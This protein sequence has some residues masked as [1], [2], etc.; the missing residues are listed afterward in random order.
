MF[1][2]K[3][4]NDNLNRIETLIGENCSIVGNL[5]GTGLLKI[6]GVIE[7]DIDWD[8]DII[9]GIN[10]EVNGAIHC[11]NA[12][13]SGTVNGNVS[14]N[15][16]LTIEKQGKIKGDIFIKKLIINESGFLDGKCTMVTLNETHILLPEN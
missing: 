9:V 7:G 5:S 16:S 11:N 6:D 14:C 15:N 13:I 10:G 8:D 3:G 12:F 4:K 1:Y 2:D